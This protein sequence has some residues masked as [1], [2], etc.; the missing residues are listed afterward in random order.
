MSL[1]TQKLKPDEQ[2]N[3]FLVRLKFKLSSNNTQLNYFFVILLLPTLSE[4]TIANCGFVA[5]SL[6]ANNLSAIAFALV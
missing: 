2:K 4:F 6:S 5:A 1:S 3:A